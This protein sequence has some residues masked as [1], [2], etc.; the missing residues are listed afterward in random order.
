MKVLFL[1]DVLLQ[2][3][4]FVYVILNLAKYLTDV[5]VPVLQ[6]PIQAIEVGN[7]KSQD[8]QKVGIIQRTLFIL[9]CLE[10]RNL[11]PQIQYTTCCLAL[12]KPSNWSVVQNIYRRFITVIK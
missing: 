10:R 11:S 4:T 1:D 7:E 12:R 9:R 6:V 8:N 2:Q 3:T 5:S